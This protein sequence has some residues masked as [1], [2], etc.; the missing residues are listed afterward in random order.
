MWASRTTACCAAPSWRMF[1]WLLL[2]LSPLGLLMHSRCKL[3]ELL[4]HLP[5]AP[6]HLVPC[7]WKLLYHHWYHLTDWLSTTMSAALSDSL[8]HT[9]N[10]AVAGCITPTAAVSL[11]PAADRTTSAMQGNKMWLII[12]LYSCKMHVGYDVLNTKMLTQRYSCST[13]ALGLQQQCQ[14]RMYG[15]MRSTRSAAA[16]RLL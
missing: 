7:L 4:L 14:Q 15:V 13:P 1:T 5:L 12:V 9:S 11:L 16:P 3:L 10:R 2:N 6:L 8:T